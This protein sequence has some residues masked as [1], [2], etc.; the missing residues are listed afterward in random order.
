MAFSL[1][2]T[3]VVPEH[4]ES[5]Y[6]AMNARHRNNFRRLSRGD[7]CIFINKHNGQDQCRIARVVDKFVY[8]GDQNNWPV[9]A[10]NGAAWSN[11]FELTPPTEANLSYNLL[12]TLSGKS[13]RFVWQTQTL[14]SVA[15]A[16]R[17]YRHI[18]NML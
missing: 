13:E 4:G 9:P 1:D 12:R 17:V 18:Y 7:I 16:P 10:P 3:M 15:A 5:Y 2:N 6:W 11:V 14:L 8:D